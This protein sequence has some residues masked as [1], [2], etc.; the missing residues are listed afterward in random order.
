LD[1]GLYKERKKQHRFGYSQSLILRSHYLN[2]KEN[3]ATYIKE[4]REKRFIDSDI[5][6][7]RVQS[8]LLD[9]LQYMK[10]SG[11]PR[12]KKDILRCIEL[13]GKT[14]GAFTERIEL[15]QVD[16]SSA[17][18]KLIE[19]AQEAEVRSITTTTEIAV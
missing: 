11:D 5:G 12:Y 1:V 14:V 16:P 7:A 3:V 18:D 13:L 8:E 4:I 19:M 17:L 15:T 2:S 6:K 9:Q 10:A